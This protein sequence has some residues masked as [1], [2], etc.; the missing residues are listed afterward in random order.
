MRENISIELFSKFTYEDDISSESELFDCQE[1]MS[2]L[3]EAR[4]GKMDAKK[5]EELFRYDP[6]ET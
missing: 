1:A 3:D 6:K 5:V 4:M 2:M